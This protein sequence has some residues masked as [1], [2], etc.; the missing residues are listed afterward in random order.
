MGRP[1]DD[2]RAPRHASPVPYGT[3]MAGRGLLRS[4]RVG[5][6][7]LRPPRHLGETVG[8]YW[9]FVDAMWLLVV[10]TVYVSTTAT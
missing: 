10:A 6:S 5:R 3:R 7:V 1:T 9:H 8:M 2:G 4:A